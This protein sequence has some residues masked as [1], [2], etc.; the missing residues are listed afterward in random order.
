MDGELIFC[1]FQMARTDAFGISHVFDVHWRISTQTLF[2]DFL[3]FEELEA[4]AIPI[5]ALGR[6]ARTACGVHALLLACVHPVMHHRNSDRTIWLYDIDRL[7][8]CLSEEE[9]L[10]F[11]N[12]ALRKKMAEICASELAKAVTRFETPVPP[13]VMRIMASA[14][15]EPAAVYLR[16]NRRWHHELIWNV[17]ALDRWSGR[18]R[19]LREV[20]FPSPRYM[21]TAYHLG[22][23]GAVL[24][25]ALYVHRCAYGLFKILAGQK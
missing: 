8:R 15:S 17:C 13:E 23:H 24:L 2:A 10:R 6:H 22:P 20:L 14:S 5:Q 25:P 1:Q 11:A 19:L 7:V 9:L 4:Q 3:T 18:F 16:A 21:L 12:L